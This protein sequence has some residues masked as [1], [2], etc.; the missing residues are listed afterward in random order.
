VLRSSSGAFAFLVL[1][2]G[3]PAR[4]QSDAGTKLE[5]ALV[6]VV[7]GDTDTGIG[8][9]AI[10]SLARPAPGNEI[11]RWKLEGFA[12]A[13][14]RS[15]PGDG[16][17]GSPY[18]DV[19]LQFTRK[20]LAAGRLRLELR[21]AY[22]SEANMRYYGLGNAS[23]A[24]LDEVASRD[25]FQR[26]HPAAHVKVQYQLAGPLELGLG[27][28]YT[29]NWFTFGPDS[30][31][32]R[33]AQQGSDEVRDVVKVDPR[34]G[35]HV[36]Q[37]ALI[38]DSRDDEVAPSIGQ[39]HIV[40]VRGSPWQTASLPYRYLGLSAS[41]SGF[42]P[43]LRPERLILAGRATADVLIGDAPFYELSRF[44]ETSAV[45][46]PKYVR[47]VPSNRYY[48]KRK[49]MANTEL[50]AHVWDFSAGKSRYQLGITGFFDFGRVWA[51]LESRPQLDGTGLGLKYGTGAG[52][53]LQKDKTFVLR[54]DVAWSPDAR[55]LGGYLLAEHIF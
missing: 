20:D 35:L 2:L 46:G 13:T 38:F 12:F 48:G 43:L 23:P 40:Q 7:G 49:L 36:M 53:R 41:V 47:G 54:G 33:D 31:L 37:A 30:T 51:D 5:R 26:V 45:G 17:L 22:T 19:F 6:P 18:Q 27:T 16:G 21:A 1:A 11:F 39:H 15:E 52:L 28:M 32:L 9:G 42:V 29:Q 3:W 44:D 25:F 8:A 55:P 10:A 24:P 4:A 14:V 50:R 34:H